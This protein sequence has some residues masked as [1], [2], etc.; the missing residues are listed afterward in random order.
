MI[1]L[2]RFTLYLLTILLISA[3]THAQQIDITPLLSPIPSLQR[4]P[5]LLP[6]P[7]KPATSEQEPLIPLQPAVETLSE[8]EQYIA[9]KIDITEK[10]LEILQKYGIVFSQ[11]M[12]PPPPGKI[13]LTVRIVK[14][15][16]DDKAAKKT[17]ESKK[18][19]G[20]PTEKMDELAGA[21]I[22]AGFLIAT[23]E[24][25]STAFKILGIQSPFTTTVG[26]RQFG[27]DLFMQQPSTFA[28]LENVP[29]GPDYVL[30]PG[31]EI[32]IAVW[33]KIEGLW[34]VI[35]DRDGNINLPKVGIIGVTGLTF[36]EL[37]EVLFKEFSKYYTGFEMNVSMGSLRTIR[38][39]V[40]G[41]ARRPGA[42][43]I[44][45]LSTLINALF[46][47]SGP[48][49]TGSMRDIQVK[50]NG[51]TIVHFD[52]YD[53]LL[54]GDRANDI[55]LM[56]EDVIFIPPVGPLAGISG[57]V[58][59]PAIYEMK[60]R[61]TIPQLIEMAGGLSAVAFK[62]RVQIE[63]IVEK[64][65]Q[66]VFDANLN[67]IADKDITLQSGD[68]VKV[69]QIAQD[70]AVVRLVGAVQRQGEYG[71]SPGMTVKDLISIAGGLK[72]YAYN[73]EAEL[74]RLYVTDEGPKTEKI[75]IDIGKAL[76]GEPENNVVLQANDYL[77]VRAV[78]EWMLYQ[79]VTI[80][81]EITFP[82]TYSI[83]KGER[84]SSLIKRAGGYTDTAY[85]R[86]AV[87][88]R[89]RVR[90]LQKKGLDEMIERLE[91]EIL[92]AGSAQISTAL[93]REEIEAKKA[94]LEQQRKLIES[95]KKIEPLG[96]LSIRL[97]HLRLLK[98]SEYD[99]ELEE[100]DKLYIPV[101]NS[102]VNVMGAVMSQGSFI[103]SG[104]LDYKDYIELTGGYTR[105][106][107]KKN[108]YVLKVDGTA[109]KLSGG[110][111]SW[112]SSKSRWEIAGFGEEIEEIEPGDTIVVP[113]KLERIAWLREI[114][115]ITQILYQITLAAGVI[116]NLF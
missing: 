12:Q 46:E 79:T 39:Y 54:K 41:N 101:K 88:T 77:F 30:G 85:L 43:T 69:F 86:G 42:Y 58:N 98:G 106:A 62:G 105:H 96:R 25:L 38:I 1:K 108:V 63:K 37:K 70:R 68:V 112:N 113:E 34:N 4:Q 61:T 104:N 35:V 8:F 84:L 18:I 111:F 116:V 110:L 114:K 31:D 14:V 15:P 21:I 95:M 82:G 13:K 83:T 23:Q 57:S 11:A 32:R 24:Q 76:A 5:Q 80:Q 47:A 99:I 29:V 81:G 19:P 87:F 44:S 2:R 102:I 56:P 91:R 78:P 71:A 16:E 109:R 64:G 90:E 115:D 94:E 27:Y 9:E 6:P 65:R 3:S 73:K 22:D 100:G 36:K 107:D 50:R 45:S 75:V 67:E 7:K 49:K 28:P 52:M 97:A 92:T 48:G 89:T 53:F 51:E 20:K 33:G 93:S 74:T 55:R 66:I 59:N 26:I 72:Y 17:D 103:Y 40:I 60:G 10:Q